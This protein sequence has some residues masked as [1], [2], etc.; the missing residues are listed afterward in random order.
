MSDKLSTIVDCLLL[1][2]QRIPA[3]A[4]D[5]SNEW[6]VCSAAYEHAVAHLIEEHDWKFA[7]DI[8]DLTRSGDSVDAN[9]TD[10]YA[11]P[12]TA[13][14][15]ISILLDDMATTWK[16]VGNKVLVNAGG[17]TTTSIVSAKIVKQPG[18]EQWPPMFVSALKE[19]VFSGIES[20][21]KK[22]QKVAD[23]HLA[24]A[25]TFLQRARS[26]TDQE[27]PKRALFVSGA[28]SARRLRRG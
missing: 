7:T 15:I 2:G 16:I 19:W 24:K 25:D 3:V 26:R 13:L 23:V 28:R 22:D 20:G 21:L 4:D 14:H 5:G 6:N 18:P 17:A 12:A 1:K 9:F 11:R 10:A 27:E 8:V